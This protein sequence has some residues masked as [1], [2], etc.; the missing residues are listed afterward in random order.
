M[1]ME[2]YAHDLFEGHQVNNVPPCS[3]ESKKSC[4]EKFRAE[5]IKGF[6]HQLLVNFCKLQY[7]NW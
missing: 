1:H 5:K 2:Y 6:A 3:F 7:V 4:A